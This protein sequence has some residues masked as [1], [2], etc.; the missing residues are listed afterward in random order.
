MPVFIF[1][2]FAFADYHWDTTDWAPH[3]EVLPN[4]SE[5]PARE[6][7]DSH[8]NASRSTNSN[9]TVQERGLGLLGPDGGSTES[10]SD[11][12]NDSYQRLL[13]ETDGSMANMAPVQNYAVHPNS[14][15]PQYSCSN[16][17]SRS[18]IVNT[19]YDDRGQNELAHLS[20]FTG[21]D[22]VSELGDDV[23][24]SLGGGLSRG[25]SLSEISNLCEIED[26]EACFTEDE[27]DEMPTTAQLLRGAKPT[28]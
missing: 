23:S 17:A 13:N 19:S 5:L 26:S 7:P 16:A 3:P 18:D 15:L 14:Y 27:L 22:D 25:G 1:S 20:Q 21:G 10:S 2:F 9:A 12:Q 24:V 4:I 8:S 11:S 6:V 28:T